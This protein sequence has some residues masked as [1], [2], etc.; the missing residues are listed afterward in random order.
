M[1]PLRS[2]LRVRD[3]DQAVAASGRVRAGPVRD[4]Q[5]QNDER[6]KSG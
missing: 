5:A 3:P 4:G 2:I 6:K 1:L